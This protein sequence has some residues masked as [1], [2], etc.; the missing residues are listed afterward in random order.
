MFNRILLSAGM[1]GILAALALTGA[2]AIWVTPLILQAEE[3]E[4]AAHVATA[5]HHAHG[6]AEHHHDEAAWQPEN[7]WQRTLSTAASNSLMSIGFALMLCGFYAVRPPA[8]LIHGFWWGAGGYF[9]F[10]AAPAS[11]LPPELPGTAAAELV[12][13]QYWWLGT[14]VAT[15]VGLGLIFL[16]SRNPWRLAGVVLLAL[17]H[18]I[19]APQLSIVESTA[20]ESLQ[21]SF[22]LA[23]FFINAVFWLLL[24]AASAAAFRYFSRQAGNQSED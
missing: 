3:Y 13:R 14:S 4:D 20:P 11:G 2:Q 16:Q 8:R 1:A 17:P 24:G 15:A 18:L 19:G 10:F 9:I 6:E 5:E 21:T 7:G 22:R 23:T 12:A